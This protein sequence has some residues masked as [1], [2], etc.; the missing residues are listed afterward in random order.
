MTRWIARYLLALVLVLAAAPALALPLKPY[1]GASMGNGKFEADKFPNDLDFG[2]ANAWKVFGGLQLL[3]FLGVEG[4]YA[5]LGGFDDRFNGGKVEADVKVYGVQAV[6]GLKLFGLLQGFGKVGATRWDTE[7]NIFGD[8]QT[9]E[10][11]VDLGYG[12]G[13]QLNIGSRF[14]IRAEWEHFDADP[15]K[16]DSD[17]ELVTAGIVLRF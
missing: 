4:T 14:G 15:E 11:G 10:S 17:L 9:Y 3:P 5:D 7:T 13:L 16:V 2:D 8:S 6:F 1:I 12:A